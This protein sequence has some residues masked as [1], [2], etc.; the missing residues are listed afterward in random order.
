MAYNFTFDLS[1]FSQSFFSDV[2]KLSER[3]N[4][5]KKVGE[6]A[7]FLVKKFKV[8]EITGLPISDAFGVMED[9][10]DAYVK[11]MSQRKTFLKTKNR[12]LLL[13]HCSRKFMDSRCK[14]K[15]DTDTASY[16]CMKCSSDCSVNKATEIGKKKGYDVYVL[17]GGSCVK[18]IISRYD[19]LV[20]VACTEEIK[21]ANKL[22]DTAKIPAQSVPLTKNGCSGTKFNMETL[23]NTL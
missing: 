5:H 16:H 10:I 4:I 13:P 18:N 12:V 20:G 11:N 19:G 1:K 23:V 22:L 21:M 2:A 15:F 17:P 9:L 6:T 3:K 8:H 14:A 7:R